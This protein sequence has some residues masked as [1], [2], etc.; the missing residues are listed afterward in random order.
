MYYRLQQFDKDGTSKIAPTIVVDISTRE[1]ITI[2]PNPASNQLKII[3][4]GIRNI[5]LYDGTGKLA[6]KK[7]VSE[8]ENVLH[9]D[10]ALLA[11][12]MYVV[13][14]EKQDAKIVLEKLFLH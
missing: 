12:G 3:G 11:R 14:I 13:K 1:T 9:L 8:N 6:M 5:Q 10:I 2:T 4:K 7:N